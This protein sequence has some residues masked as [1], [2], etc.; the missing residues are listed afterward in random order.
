MLKVLR[1]CLMVGMA[2]LG[3]AGSSRPLLASDLY[4]TKEKEAMDPGRKPAPGKAL[5]YLARPQ[6]M[7]AVVKVKTYLDGKPLGFV[8]SGSFLAVEVEPG[9]HEFVVAAENAGFLEAEVLADKVYLVQVAIHMGMWKARTHFEV[10]RP[11]S[12]ALKEIM[13]KKDDLRAIETTAE[14]M[15]WIAKRQADFDQTIAEYRKKGEEFEILKPADG[16]EALPW[17]K[18]APAAK[19]AEAAPAKPEAAP[20]SAKPAAEPAKPAAAPEPAKPEAEPAKPAIEPAPG[21][22]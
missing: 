3:V 17:A 7:G 22:P 2:M 4:V 10:A 18:P 20:E 19:P 1:T 6:R 16:G 15:A 14:G 11:G 13:E 21:K 12:D 9:K 5:V 8:M